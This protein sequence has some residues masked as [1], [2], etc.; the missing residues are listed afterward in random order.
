M[1]DSHGLLD[2]LRVQENYQADEELCHKPVMV[3]SDCFSLYSRTGDLEWED[4]I[5][6]SKVG[7]SNCQGPV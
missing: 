6:V 2:N 1:E 4:N 7:L 3:D 5:T